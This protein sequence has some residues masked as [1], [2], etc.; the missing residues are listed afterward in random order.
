MTTSRWP[1]RGARRVLAAAVTAAASLSP[2]AACGPTS[3]GPTS[4]GP[5]SAAPAP[6]SPVPRPAVTRLYAD[7]AN[8]LFAAAAHPA[9]RD[10]AAAAG[11]T[12]HPTTPARL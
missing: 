6:A 5:P 12:A 10:P 2:V 11:L 4:P 1:W 7:P 3:P 9:R 8:S